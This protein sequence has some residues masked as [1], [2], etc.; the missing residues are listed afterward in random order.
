MKRSILFY[1]TAIS[2]SVLMSTGC[3]FV[4]A[5]SKKYALDRSAGGVVALDKTNSGIVTDEYKGI[6]FNSIH[7]QGAYD[8]RYSVGECEVR[9]SA[10]DGLI[11]HLTVNIRDGVL[12]ISPDE[13]WI[14]NWKDVK[15]I[16]SSPSLDRLEIQGAVDFE[17]EQVIAGSAFELSVE[18]AGDVD[19]DRLDARNVSIRVAGAGDIDI[20]RISCEVISAEMDGASDMEISGK[21]D[22]ARFRINGVGSLDI[23]GLKCPDVAYEK[24]GIARIRK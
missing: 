9:L 18:G 5:N 6:P 24:N 23:R 19:I 12:S 13:A 20:E 4:S 17:A 8:V 7:C 22:S 16:V 2:I 3:K 14:R 15:V 11:S 21:A 10:P 1:L